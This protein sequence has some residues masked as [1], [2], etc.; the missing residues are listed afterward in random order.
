[1]ETN[2]IQKYYENYQ[3]ADELNQTFKIC[4]KYNQNPK[5]EE[6]NKPKKSLSL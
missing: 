4:Q 6:T 2:A 1:M 3:N 5:M